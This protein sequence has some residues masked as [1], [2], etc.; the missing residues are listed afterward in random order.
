MKTEMIGDNLFL[1][2]GLLSPEECAVWIDRAED[3]GFDEA[4][5]ST[6]SGQQMVKN[7][8][9]NDRLML[10]STDDAD[11]LWQRLEPQ[12]PEV[13]RSPE[14]KSRYGTGRHEAVGLNER[15]RFYRY[16]PGQRFKM[17]RDG[18][19]RRSADELS[20]LTLLV[21]LNDDFEGGSTFVMSQAGNSRP[22][23]VVP[24][25]GLALLFLHDLAH[26]GQAV[27]SGRKYVLRSDVMF[28][29]MG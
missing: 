21:Y 14:V 9:N 5:I 10:D 7:V 20:F 29:T 2:H 8:R 3:I 24:R 1:V 13:W 12:F 16:E 22:C 11:Q 23:D 17:H 6:E 19:F 4:P 26:E 27:R 15:I 25:T 18:T 28:R